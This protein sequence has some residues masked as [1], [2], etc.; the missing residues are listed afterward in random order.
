VR[1]VPAGGELV[2]QHTYVIGS[3]LDAVHAI[4]ARTEDKL[5][6][7][8]VAITAPAPN[9]TVTSRLVSVSGNASDNGGVRALSVN[10][11]AVA[12]SANGA[13]TAT[14][15][16]VPGANTINVQASDAEG[17]TTQAQVAVT[18]AVPG[19]PCRVP[20]VV[21]LT[22]KRITISY[23]KGRIVTQRVKVGAKVG[24]G[25]AVGVTVQGAKPKPKLTAKQRA[26]AKAKAL[27]KAKAK[28]LAKAKAK[29]H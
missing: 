5:A 20:K 29:S 27:A 6:S 23:R 15:A 22:R 25:T 14:L 28:A 8:A 2:L 4:A 13:W 24:N 19:A 17:N 16:L 10:G 7:P 9:T 11:A 1:T 21:G 3:S 12:L 18:Y 26:K